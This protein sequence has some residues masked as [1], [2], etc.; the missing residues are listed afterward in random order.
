MDLPGHPNSG[1]NASV[2]Y[3]VF[4]DKYSLYIYIYA[5]KQ[6][7]SESLYS[8]IHNYCICSYNS[9]N[10]ISPHLFGGLPL[11]QNRGQTHILMH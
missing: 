11:I 2:A 10:I 7:L 6:I 9:P 4:F 8:H 3:M 5:N 1:C